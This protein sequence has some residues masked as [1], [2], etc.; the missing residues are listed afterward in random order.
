[1]L[2]T[3]GAGNVTFATASG[4]GGADLYAANE[5]SPVAQPSAVG[6]NAIAIGQNT[7]AGTAASHENAIAIG[8]SSTASQPVQAT[9]THA[10]AIGTAYNGEVASAAGAMAFGSGGTV[11]NSVDAMA[12]GRLAEAKNQRAI[13]LGQSR[14]DGIESFVVQIDSTATTY[15]ATGSNSIAMG[16]QAKAD[17]NYS[18]ALGNTSATGVNELL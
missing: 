10:I 13:A 16:R 5:S 12:L 11:A 17:G 14:S 8:G 3:D 1:M 6:A 15:G 2:T 9:A 4:G 18:V 7:D